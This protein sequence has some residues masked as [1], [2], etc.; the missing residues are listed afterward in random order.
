[1]SEMVL[2]S[3]KKCLQN[4]R[5]GHSSIFKLYHLLRTIGQLDDSRNMNVEEIFCNFLH[6]IGHQTKIEW[7]RDKL[8]GP[9]R[10]LV[11]NFMQSSIVC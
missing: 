8:L 1:M 6:I 11:E 2:D 5:M 10:Q 3:N 9:M 4:C 7:L